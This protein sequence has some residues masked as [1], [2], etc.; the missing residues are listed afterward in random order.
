MASFNGL[1]EIEPVVGNLA[2]SVVVISSNNPVPA[3]QSLPMDP[4]VTFDQ[5]KTKIE[6]LYVVVSM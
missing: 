6:G 1:I 3:A 2:H 5:L 4:N